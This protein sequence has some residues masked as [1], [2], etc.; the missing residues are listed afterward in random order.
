MKAVPSAISS[1]G[2]PA[3]VDGIAADI[4]KLVGNTPM[5]FLNRVVG[6]VGT[7]TKP[8]LVHAVMLAHAPASS[9]FSLARK[10]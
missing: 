2:A 6:K 7:V 9:G 3:K 1:E 5:V 4:T 10:L 8:N